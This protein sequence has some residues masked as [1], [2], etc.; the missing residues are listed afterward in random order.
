ML[1]K[2]LSGPSN[3]TAHQQLQW[4]HAAVVL[5]DRV[6]PFGLQQLQWA[7]AAVVLHDRVSPFGHAADDSV[8]RL[9]SNVQW[10]WLIYH[11]AATYTL[12]DV[13]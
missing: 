2:T 7:R 9:C 11:V 1:V 4:A 10:Q 3:I 5:Q 13:L 6:S 8:Y 12:P